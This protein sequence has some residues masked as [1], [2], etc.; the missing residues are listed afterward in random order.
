M[1]EYHGHIIP[2]LLVQ[3]RL[4][5]WI[6]EQCDKSS[7]TTLVTNYFRKKICLILCRQSKVGITVMTLQHRRAVAIRHEDIDPR[8]QLSFHICKIAHHPF[9]HG[10]L[11]HFFVVTSNALRFLG[12]LF[13]QFV[14]EV[15]R[16]WPDTS[17][18]TSHVRHMKIY[19]PADV[20]VSKRSLD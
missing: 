5:T 8:R 4:C 18:S 13:S 14:A 10:W 2:S 1:R 15:S 17:L 6:H 3:V 20:P 12:L 9:H 11:R 19:M 7:A 16:L